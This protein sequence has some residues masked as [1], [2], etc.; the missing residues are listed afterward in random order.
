MKLQAVKFGLAA[1]IV[2]G[3]FWLVGRL[4]LLAAPFGPVRG[5][6]YAVQGY[7]HG[8]YMMGGNSPYG[9]MAGLGWGGY[10]AGLLVGLIVVPLV[11]GVAAWATATVYN[12][13]LDRSAP[14]NPADQAPD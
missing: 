2:A 7:M 1:A 8:G 10:F 3:V 9:H 6:D 14:D 11:A 5:G 12:R 13:L 4:L